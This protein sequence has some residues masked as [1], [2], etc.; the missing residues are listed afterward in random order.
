MKYVFMVVIFSLIS[1]F[2]FANTGTPATE[3][4]IEKSDYGSQKIQFI[5]IK[6]PMKIYVKKPIK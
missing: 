2:N 3:A 4:V 5:D 6:R 1:S